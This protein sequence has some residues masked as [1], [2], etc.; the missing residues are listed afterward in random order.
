MT[1][2]FVRTTTLE[3]FRRVV[4]TSWGNEGELRTYIAAGQDDDAGKTWKMDAGTAWHKVL[5]CPERCERLNDEGEEIYRYGDYSF[6]PLAVAEALAT[7]GGRGLYEVPGNIVFQADGRRSSYQVVVTG[8][9]DH[10]RGLEVGDFKTKFST[11]DAK[12]YEQ[13]L[14][15]RFYLAM[16]GAWFTYYLFHFKTP[17]CGHCE[18]KGVKTFRFWPYPALSAD[19]GEW[20]MRFIGWAERNDLIEPLTKVRRT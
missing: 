18:Y 13:S 1:T 6:S 12:D 10:L 14:Q 20:V 16:G 8:T 2:L 15:W 19:C 7:I 5:A 17:K 4:S 11:P 9:R 3:S